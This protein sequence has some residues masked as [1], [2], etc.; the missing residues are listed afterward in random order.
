MGPVEIPTRCGTRKGKKV[1]IGLLV[2][3][4]AAEWTYTLM[5]IG[6]LDASTEA[7]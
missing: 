3:I 2:V 7:Y 4:L 5:L 6:S 1:L